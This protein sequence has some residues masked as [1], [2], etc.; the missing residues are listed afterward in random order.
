MTYVL[1]VDVGTT[2]IKTA[3]V[4]IKDFSVGSYVSDRARIIIPDKESAEVDL[5]DLW[6]QILNLIKSLLDSSS[7]I[8]ENDIKALIFTAHMAGVAPIDKNGYPLRNALIWLDERAK[9]LPKKLFS[10][11]IK[12]EGYNIFNLIEFLRLTGGAPSKTGKDPI[13]KILWIKLYEPEVYQSTFKFLDIKGYLIYSATRKYVTTPD[14]A[15]LTWLADTRGTY[16]KWSI[17]LFKK[18]GI[19]L[20]KFPNIV[21]SNEIVGSLK[22]EV[23]K[24]LNLPRDLPVI[25][26]CGDLTS[27]AL[28]SGAIKENEPHIYIGT[29]SWIAAHV[30]KRLLDISHYMGSLYSG[31]PGKYLYI[32][33]QEIAGGAL[34]YIVEL[35]YGEKVSYEKVNEEVSKAIVGSNKIIFLPWMYGERSPIDDPYIRGGF[36]NLKLSDDK[37]ALIRSVMEGVAYNLRWAFQYFSRKIGWNNAIKFVGGGALSDAWSQILADVLNVKIIRVDQPQ[38]ASIRGSAVLASVGLKIYS[39]FNEAVSHIKYDKIF[40]PNPKNKRV[41]DKLFS[42]FEKIYSSIKNIYKDLNQEVE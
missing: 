5:E 30:S 40:E 22:N 39:S 7:D 37:K 3:L 42:N 41:Y 19:D 28:G 32:A 21:S 23:S 25:A 27:A 1:C 17:K 36:I 33:E 4:S 18:Y 11:L 6:N 9:G 24:D 34:D 26:G 10:G 13:S 12:L 29:S 16:P 20:E 38:F 15:H 8:E 31:I 35:I 14:E 2:N